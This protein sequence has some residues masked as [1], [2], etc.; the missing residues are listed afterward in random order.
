MCVYMC[1]CGRKGGEEKVERLLDQTNVVVDKEGAMMG[2]DDI[3]A[4]G[5]EIKV[6]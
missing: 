6:R 3:K 2:C 1:V 4:V 5:E